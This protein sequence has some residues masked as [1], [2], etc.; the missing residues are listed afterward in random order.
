MRMSQAPNLPGPI[1]QVTGRYAEGGSASFP[2]EE[3]RKRPSRSGCALCAYY[4]AGRAYC[5]YVETP[6]TI[7]FVCP[8]LLSL[9]R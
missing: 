3:L 8:W 7:L 2:E 1:E 4:D 5:L 9:Q 6:V